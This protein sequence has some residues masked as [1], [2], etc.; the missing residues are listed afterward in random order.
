[1]SKAK[2]LEKLLQRFKSKDKYT[3]KDYISF[4]FLRKAKGGYSIQL[5]YEYEHHKVASP[6][7]ILDS[8]TT[9]QKVMD[10][11]EWGINQKQSKITDDDLDDILGEE[12]DDTDSK[13]MSGW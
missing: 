6:P 2:K 9:A 7:V 3:P 10:M 4:S 1:M 8:W 12:E 5:I 13:K 11:L